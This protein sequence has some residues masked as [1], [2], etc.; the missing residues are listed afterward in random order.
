MKKGSFLI[1]ASRGTVV[2]IS[3]LVEALKEGHIA[4]AAIGRL[5][6]RTGKQ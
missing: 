4:G 5:P 2:V 3:D 1:N 6:Q